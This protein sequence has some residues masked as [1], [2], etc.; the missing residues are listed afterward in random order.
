MQSVEYAQETGIWWCTHSHIRPSWFGLWIPEAL[1]TRLLVS[2]ENLILN[3]GCW[4][5][6]STY[7]IH[8]WYNSIPLS[9]NSNASRLLIFTIFTQI[10][11]FHHLEDYFTLYPAG[12]WHKGNSAGKDGQ[13][14]IV[15]YI[16]K[17]NDMQVSY[18]ST[19]AT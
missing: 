12:T 11:G 14:Q 1:V 5:W 7:C 4:T 8:H 2:K 9:R 16:W 6:S 13:H 10:Q 15:L 3:S 19:L 17:G 18:Q